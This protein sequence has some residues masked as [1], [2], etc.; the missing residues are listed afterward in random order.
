VLR[1]LDFYISSSTLIYRVDEFRYPIL[2]RLLHVVSGNAFSNTA[3]SRVFSP[4]KLRV[5][6][7]LF[8]VWSAVWISCIPE[9][10]Y[11]AFCF[12]KI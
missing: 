4:K 7:R 5:S 3:L 12:M 2:D 11:N 8:S 10:L 9:L 6:P 1:D